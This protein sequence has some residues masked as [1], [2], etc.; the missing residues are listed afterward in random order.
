[1]QSSHI[2][3]DE[4][5]SDM[6]ITPSH[7]V[8]DLA[9]RPFFILGSLFGIIALIFWAVLLSNN[10]LV[11][12]V[13]PV[14]LWHGHEMLYGFVAAFLVGFLLTA[15]QNWTGLRSVHGLSLL[16][17]VMLW[18]AGRMVMWPGLEISG[19]LRFVADGSFLLLSAVFVGRL[20][21][22]KAQKRNY[23]AVVA[24]LI[25]LADN[26]I[27]HYALQTGDWLMARQSLYSVVF[28]ITLMMTIIGGRVI[29]MFT[30]NTTQIPARPRKAWIDKTGLGLLWLIVVIFLLQLQPHLKNEIFAT[31]LIL[32]AIFIGLRCSQWRLMSTWHH[33][34][35]WSLHLAYWC[36]P[37]ALSLLALHYA[38]SIAFS[39]GL[40]VLTVGAMAGL[41]LSMIARVSLGHTG[42][43][44]VASRLITVALVMI[45]L[46]AVVRV[47][48]AVLLSE[49]TIVF[50]HLSITLWGGAFSLFLY[51]Y[52]PI[53]TTVRADAGR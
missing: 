45:F 46:A 15:I 36:I 25:L 37:L 6:K 11:N 16:L 19:W 47:P 5:D 22:R 52:L 48:L 53:L 18:L 14:Q 51:Q 40:H 42:R 30:A 17:L 31:V 38:G 4:T 29:P 12:P 24:L 26:F 33:P 9:F 27:F 21:Q 7:P 20:L 3:F 50:W 2:L 35:L 39:I 43:R 8:L 49:Y 28:V 34:L 1:M 32:A 10:D 23:F 13:Y 44:I 41:I